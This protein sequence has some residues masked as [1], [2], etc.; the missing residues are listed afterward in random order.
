M[1]NYIKIIKAFGMLIFILILGTSGYLYIEDNWTLLDALYM[2]VITITTV[3]FKEIHELSPEGKVFTIFIIFLG[4]SIIAIVL[5]QVAQVIIESEIKNLFSKNKIKKK[6]KKM[7]NHYIVCGFGRTGTSICSELKKALIP[8]V[9]IETKEEAIQA[10]EELGYNVIKG[11]ATADHTLTEA[12]IDRAAGLIAALSADVDNFFISLAARELNPTIFIIARGEDPNVEGR[13][14]RA[15]A[16]IVV[17]PIKLGGEQI[18]NLLS[19]HINGTTSD[20]QSM[21][22]E[23]L[24]GFSMKTYITKDKPEIVENILKKTGAISAISIKYNDG[25]FENNPNK[26]QEVPS[27]SVVVLVMCNT[28]AQKT[29]IVKRR[30]ESKTVLIA[31][32][33]NAL[34][35]LFARKIHSAGYKVITAKD[36]QEA[37]NITEKEVPNLVVL[38]VTMPHKSGFEV[39]QYIKSNPK[40]KDVLVILYSSDDTEEFFIK[41]K[42]VGA[43]ITMR[44]SSKSSELLE[45]INHLLKEDATNGNKTSLEETQ[46]EHNLSIHIDLEQLND[47]TDSDTDL[48][49]DVIEMFIEN[50][51][52]Q[53]D[54]IKLALD[55]KVF[56]DIKDAAHTIKGAAVNIG[57]IK[58]HEIVSE[59]EKMALSENY[60]KCKLLTNNLNDYFKDLKQVIVDNNYFI[61]SA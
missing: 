2:T 19:Q 60:N 45:I 30:I 58:I 23:G 33:H 52:E 25:N 31:D 27:N 49:K 11:N 41:G 6:V 36:G 18:A 1:K 54:I 59:L 28:Q 43:D 53:S 61:N 38:D 56:K 29:A 14:L 55:H 7:K 5:S 48:I 57:F 26:T 47:I 15:G 40:L 8:F 42:R 20:I 50:T 34:R 13:I 32:D 4:Y 46:T 10:A 21:H 16:D 35:T 39:C 9:L 44:K 3:G 12:G 22:S 17:S 51:T 24:L 37:I